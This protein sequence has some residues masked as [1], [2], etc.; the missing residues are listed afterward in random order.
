LA[1]A[2]TV[3]AAPAD[4]PVIDT[5]TGWSIRPVPGD[6]AIDTGPPPPPVQPDSPV[7]ARIA[8][9]STRPRCTCHPVMRVAYP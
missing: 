7:Q 5:L 9:I 1:V 6:T 2:V 3:V 8:V 4:S